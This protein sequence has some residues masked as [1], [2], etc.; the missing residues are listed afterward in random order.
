[1]DTK[2]AHARTSENKSTPMFALVL[3]VFVIALALCVLGPPITATG[4]V[5]WALYIAVV[6]GDSRHI[7]GIVPL[8]V[9]FIFAPFPSALALIACMAYWTYARD[10]TRERMLHST[11]LRRSALPRWVKHWANTYFTDEARERL[12]ALPSEKQVVIA[13]EP[14]NLQCL[15]LSL[16]FAAFGDD[17]PEA[18]GSKIRVVADVSAMMLP[19]IGELFSA[20]GVINSS[21]ATFSDYIATG[22]SIAL[23]PSGITGKEHALLDTQV[24]DAESGM[25]KVFIYTSRTR[26]GFLSMAC[27]HKLPIV[28]VLSPDEVDAY[29][30]F[31]Q[32]WRAWP[33]VVPIGRALIF[34]SKPIR[35][36]VGEPI[37]TAAYD[38]ADNE[39]MNRLAQVYR[40]AL[41]RLAPPRTELVFRYIEDC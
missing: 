32:R 1:M 9:F 41:V 35:V 3:I 40:D 7:H 11:W 4:I 2:R 16:C 18:L 37:E 30:L 38:S 39:S 31:G 6:R 14:H 36:L 26:L 5:S 22:H 34:P 25:R 27:R 20:F 15:H 8:V 33:F 17:L 28:P 29:Q 24:A 19:F 12:R 10:T 21:R 13:C 23:C